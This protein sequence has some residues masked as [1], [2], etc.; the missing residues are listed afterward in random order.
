MRPA[1][2][3]FAYAAAL[4]LG[5]PLL[6]RARWPER[7]PRLA[8]AAW[9]SVT[10]SAL[11]AVILGGLVLAVPTAG[12]S[13]G[14]GAL[15][16]ACAMALQVQY[17]SPGG[18]ALSVTGLV[19]AAGVASR[20]LY[21]TASSVAHATLQR[22][23]HRDALALIGR[24]APAKPGV[25]VIDDDALTAYCLPGRGA[26]VVLTSSAVAALDPAELD[27][28]LAHER[29]HIQGRHHWVLAGAEG[30][31]R[32][33][34]R[35]ALFR[36]AQQQVARLVEMLAD[37]RACREHD[38]LD[39]AA[40]LIALGRD[41]SPEAA[42][43]ASGPSAP[44]RIRRLISPARPL[45]RPAAA[46][47]VLLAVTVTVAPVIVAAAPAVAASLQ[48]LCPITSGPPT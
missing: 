4:M 27:A 17:F 38:R 19:L 31:A 33:F 2:V 3:L 18:A 20:C 35:V 8:I 7:S 48:N 23:T 32:A 42:L 28:V 21:T 15:L 47:G 1:L 10:A 34:P 24:P 39:I 11:L 12:I 40:A 22:R 36:V 25:I 16:R 44:D 14:L 9:Q 5:A 43:A 6:A 45:P 29:A 46:V 30:A 26:R 37:D 41:A 13:G